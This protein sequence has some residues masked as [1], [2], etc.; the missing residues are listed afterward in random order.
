MP[1]RACAACQSSTTLCMA[2]GVPEA[3]ALEQLKRFA[4]EVMPAF[5]GTKGAEPALAN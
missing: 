4:K 2:V 3:V 1:L 5:N